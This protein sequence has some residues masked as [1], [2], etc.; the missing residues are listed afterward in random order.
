MIVLALRSLGERKL[1]TALTALAVLLGVA[2]IAGTYVQTDRIRDAFESLTATVNRGTDVVVTPHQAFTSNLAPATKGID[3]SLL[4]RVRAVHGVRR[5]EGQLSD[6]GNLVIGGEAISTGFAPA[7][8]SSWSPKPFDAFRYVGG[9]P[10]RRPGEVVVDDQLAG[11]QGLRVGQH[12][13]LSTR[14][15]VQSVVISGIGVW[16]GG[17]SLGGATL[18]V[19]R[20]DD[21]QRWFQRPG[22][23][24]RIV[25]AAEPGVRPAQLA[26]AVRR[27]LPQAVT[28]KTGAADAAETADTANE[29]IGSFLTPALL[30]LSGAA[31]L[32]GAFIIFNTFS[33]TVAQRAREF[34]LLRSLGSTRA[35]VLGAVAVEALTV[36]VIASVL[37]LFAG[38]GIATLLGALFDAALDLPSGGLVLAGRTVVLALG[39]GIG[40]TLLAALVPAVRA[41]RVPPVAA[42]HAD[43]LTATGTRGARR[44]PFIAAAVS[45][46]GLLG[47]VQGLFGSGPA[48][49]RLGALAG[50][51][52]LLFVGVALVARYIVRPFAGAI[53][54]PLA[55]A[56]DEPGRLARENAMRNPARTATTSAALMV[57]LAL[58]VFVA[59]FAA[60]LKTSITGSL[61]ELVRADIA[62]TA[63]GFQPLP[64]NAQLTVRSVPG[65]DTAMGQYM[66][67]IKVNGKAANQTTDTLDGV[68]SRL[69][70]SSY[71]PKWLH[72]GTDALVGRLHGDTALIEEQFAET[73]GIAVG[74]RFRIQTPSGGTATLLAIGEY[75][76]PQ[77]LQGI[78]VD[79]STFQRVSALHDPFAFFVST[80]PGWDRADVQARVAAALERFPTAEVRSNQ[81]YRDLINEQVNQIVYLL[82]AL[83]AMSLLI[84][85]FGIANSLFLAVHERTREF[86]LLRAVGATQRQVRRVVRYESVITAVIGAL[87]GT[88][89][90]VLF[91]ALATAALADLGLGFALPAGQLAIFLVLAVVVGIVGAAVPARRAARVDV[92]DAMRH[93]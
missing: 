55:I 12:V 83:L 53:G 92:L 35:Q 54:K 8:V 34:A 24:T 61:E 37:G 38:L 81:Q 2:M 48:A 9:G 71:K 63:K 47:L 82:Y 93:D 72:G 75:R 29:A 60:G 20:L 51:A 57:G 33:I 90:G 66:D 19:P 89:V 15:G 50:G 26:A 88:A 70:L 16:G 5:A 87:L 62:V 42:L 7:V 17:T 78:M 18:V 77:I 4:V 31:L 14:S 32:V 30:T 49:S 56:F 21:V 80:A 11:D 41:T 67:A 44:K 59:V 10:P 69:L 68:E 3:E 23:L 52:V 43:P 86:G 40:V 39:V 6:S 91:A 36:G 58:V 85:L 74:D 25:I 64:P 22:D 73:H 45:L 84:S 76:D 65:V 1:R 79:L 46:L 27:A 28:V 13:G